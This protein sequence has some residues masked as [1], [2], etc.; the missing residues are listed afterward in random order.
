MFP[1]FVTEIPLTTMK[2]CVFYLFI[3][4]ARD[5]NGAVNY[6]GQKKRTYIQWCGR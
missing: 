2:L 4:I 6:G 5:Y 1:F 3:E